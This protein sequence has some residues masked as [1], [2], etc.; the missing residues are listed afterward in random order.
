MFNVGSQSFVVF[1]FYS[2]FVKLLYMFDV[3]EQEECEYK[4]LMCVNVFWKRSSPLR[5]YN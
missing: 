5:V 2:R 3:A 4:S 1:L